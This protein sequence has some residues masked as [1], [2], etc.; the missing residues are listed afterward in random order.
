MI[1][2]QL[3]LTPTTTPTPTPLLEPLIYSACSKKQ[4]M[5]LFGDIEIAFLMFQEE[6]RHKIKIEQMDTFP[7]SN[8]IKLSPAIWSMVAPHQTPAQFAPP[9]TTNYHITMNIEQKTIHLYVVFYGNRSSTSAELYDIVQKIYVW[10]WILYSPSATSVSPPATCSQTLS[11]YL[12]MTPNKKELPIRRYQVLDENNCNTAYTTACKKHTQIVL[13]RKEEWFK[14]FIHE[15]F[16]CFGMDFSHLTAYN[17]LAKKKI[18]KRFGL[19]PA[20]W[21]G[22]MSETFAEI[23]AEYVYIAFHVFATATASQ[24]P[25]RRALWT[26]WKEQIEKE[27]VFSCKQAKKV[28]NYYN[29]QE[30]R[31][32]TN[33]F[34]Y[35]V[36]KSLCMYHLDDF[37]DWVC[38]NNDVP[39]IGG[40]GFTKEKVLSFCD[41]ILY[42]NTDAEY[43]TYTEKGVRVFSTDNSLRMVSV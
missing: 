40:V 18:E 19:A 31:E 17:F 10:L 35:Y 27:R 9:Q 34:C 12:Y 1:N 23:S 24:Q 13:F 2:T 39:R 8:E 3:V 6:G 36:L 5:A 43:H 42:I 4:I 32:N 22:D 20:L 15:T 21:K 37:L 26:K 28:L 41:F 16:H 7:Q 25:K 29:G 33:V 14:V 38:E 11:I 30:Y